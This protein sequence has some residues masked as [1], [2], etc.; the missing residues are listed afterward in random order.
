MSQ[1]WPEL[2]EIALDTLTPNERQ[3]SAV[4]LDTQVFA[5]GSHVNLGRQSRDVDVATVIAFIDLEPRVNW[6]HRCRYL[7]IEPDSRQVQVVE[8]QFPPYRDTPPDAFRLIW[9]GADVPDWTLL[10]TREL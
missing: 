5:A 4:Y 10:T 9:Q 8:G 3:T 2:A 1:S 7:L 6:A